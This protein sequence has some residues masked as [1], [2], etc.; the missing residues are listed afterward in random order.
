M[1]AGVTQGKC[2]FESKMALLVKRTPGYIQR[3]IKDYRAFLNP[4]WGLSLMLVQ[5]S[6]FVLHICCARMSKV[7]TTA[8]VAKPGSSLA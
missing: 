5:R 7:Q 2:R 1:Q 3:G 6:G 4:V 8:K